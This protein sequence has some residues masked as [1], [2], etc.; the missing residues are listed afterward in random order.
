MRFMLPASTLGNFPLCLNEEL[1]ER[2]SCTFSTL[3]GHRT[4]RKGLF[5]S[6]IVPISFFSGCCSLHRH[7]VVAHN[8]NT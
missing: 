4:G 6:E 7:G 1:L 5:A 8:K 3:H 2:T